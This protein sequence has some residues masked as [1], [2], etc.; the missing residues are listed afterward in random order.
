MAA[1]HVSG[2]VALLF[3]NQGKDSPGRVRELLES[4]ADRVEAM[5]DE[6]SHEK[7]SKTT[8][9]GAGRLNLFKLLQ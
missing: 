9:Y 2:A 1:P 4:S 7:D 8:D 5:N 6:T 3:A